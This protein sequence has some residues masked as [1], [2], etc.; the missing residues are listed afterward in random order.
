MVYCDE[1]NYSY[2]SEKIFSPDRC[3]GIKAFFGLMYKYFSSILIPAQH[4][5]LCFQQESGNMAA[6]G[7]RALWSTNRRNHILCCNCSHV[8][9]G[10]ALL[11]CRCRRH[12]QMGNFHIM[13]WPFFLTSYQ[14]VEGNMLVREISSYIISASVRAKLLRL[15]F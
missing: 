2:S 3:A 13:V 4:Q 11:C 12:C 10:N 15:L 8:W 14:L 9:C 1:Q 6:S 7:H 5:F